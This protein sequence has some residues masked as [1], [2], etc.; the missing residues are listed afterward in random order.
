MSYSVFLFSNL[1]LFLYLFK[2]FEHS[3]YIINHKI[4]NLWYSDSFRNCKIWEIFGKYKIANFS[5]FRN[6]TFLELSKL[7]N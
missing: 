3:K 7:E 4:G 2:L 6:S 1:F 5:N